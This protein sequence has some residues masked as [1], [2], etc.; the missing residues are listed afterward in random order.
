M[1]SSADIHVSVFPHT[2]IID[3]LVKS[4]IYVVVD[5]KRRFAVPHVLPN[6]R[7]RY[8][9]SYIELFPEPIPA[10][11][12]TF[13]EPVKGDYFYLIDIQKLPEPVRPQEKES[14][15][16]GRMTMEHRIGPK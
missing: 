12:M 6:P 7:F 4:P 10:T 2:S 16:T 8:Y 5:L 1:A 11:S 13:Y 9:A 15:R 3:G 14:A